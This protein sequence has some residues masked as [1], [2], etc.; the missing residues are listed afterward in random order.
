MAS[1]GTIL[2]SGWEPILASTAVCLLA[3]GT[4]RAAAPKKAKQN[5]TEAQAQDMTRITM[6]QSAAFGVP[7]VRDSN[8]LTW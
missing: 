2:T 1:C 3:R 4:G 7:R 8:R 6:R 5:T